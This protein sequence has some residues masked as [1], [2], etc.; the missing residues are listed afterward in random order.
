MLCDRQNRGGPQQRVRATSRVSSLRCASAGMGKGL[1]TGLRVQGT[2]SGSCWLWA[3]SWRDWSVVL[4]QPEVLVKEALGLPQKQSSTVKRHLQGGVMPSSQPVCCESAPASTGFGRTILA[5][6]LAG[7]S[8]GRLC[9]LR[10]SRT[11]EWTVGAPAVGA[12]GAGLARAAL[13]W[14]EPPPKLPQQVWVQ[15]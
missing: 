1:V 11:S 4:H 6:P 3:D 5:A 8:R 10:A 12:V 13:G 15:S 9:K 7:A 2:D 14:A